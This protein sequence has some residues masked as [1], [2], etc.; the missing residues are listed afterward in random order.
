MRDIINFQHCLCGRIPLSGGNGIVNATVYGVTTE[1][2]LHQFPYRHEC[3]SPGLEQRIFGG[4]GGF[5]RRVHG[6]YE[7]G[8]NFGF[9]YRDADKQVVR[10]NNSIRGTLNLLFQKTSL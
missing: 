8:T 6:T 2:E 5:R 3:H 4:A 1:S 9:G 7:D 10:N